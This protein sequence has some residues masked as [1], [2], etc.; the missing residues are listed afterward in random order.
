MGALPLL[1]CGQF[2]PEY[3]L[4][5]E[6]MRGF[7]LAEI[8]PPEASDVKS[9]C[10]RV[11]LLGQVAGHAGIADLTHLG[12]FFLAAVHGQWAARVKGAA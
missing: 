6:A 3:F 4:Q 12:A 9:G 7:F 10:Q 2:T 1:A 5:E 11:G 8:L